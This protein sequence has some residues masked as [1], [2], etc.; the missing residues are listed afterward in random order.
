MTSLKD[1]RARELLESPNYAVISTVNADG[2]IHDTIVWVG[3]ENGSLSV[4]SA[5]GRIWPRNLERNP[6]VTVLVFET[7]NP[8]NFLEVRGTATRASGGADEHINSLAKKYLGVDE[9]PYRRPGE[10]RV[11]FVIEPRRVRHVKQAQAARIRG[12]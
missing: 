5:E 7:G 8:Y 4:N 2:S 11:K 1:D 10:R 6:I 9:Y 12:T 3:T